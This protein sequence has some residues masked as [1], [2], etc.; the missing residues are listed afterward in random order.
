MNGIENAKLKL[1]Y[2]AANEDWYLKLEEDLEEYDMSY[3]TTHIFDFDDV[4]INDPMFKNFKDTFIELW[5]SNSDIDPY[6]VVFKDCI[7]DIVQGVIKKVLKLERSK[8]LRKINET[9]AELL[10]E[11]EG[12]REEKE[13][14]AEFDNYEYLY[15]DQRY[16]ELRSLLLHTLPECPYP[17]TWPIGEIIPSKEAMVDFFKRGLYIN[18][19]RV[20]F[21]YYFFKKKP[22]EIAS[23]FE[24]S[25]SNV[26]III[27]RAMR[28]I[29]DNFK[30]LNLINEFNKS[31]DIEINI[32]IVECPFGCSRRAYNVLTK[33]MGDGDRWDLRKLERLTWMEVRKIH[34]SGPKVM[35]EIDGLMK[36]FGLKYI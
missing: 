13:R 25:R 32:R 15:K 7:N 20:L 10:G 12:E 28:K 18:E 29:R 2:D 27:H 16:E 9:T 14:L 30:Y 24:C 35:K 21:L 23:E 6:E 19:F 17:R 1:I 8:K 34:G 36:T 5:P 31:K 22:V 11:K 26:D 3:I 33:T 4:A